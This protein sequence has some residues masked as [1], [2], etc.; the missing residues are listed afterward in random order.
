[1]V[2]QFTLNAGKRYPTPQY[3]HL[4]PLLNIMGLQNQAWFAHRCLSVEKM[5]AVTLCPHSMSWSSVNSGKSR[6][7]PAPGSTRKRCW[8]PFPLHTC[9]ISPWHLPGMWQ[10]WLWW[11]HLLGT[12]PKAG[13]ISDKSCHCFNVLI[14]N[15]LIPG[16][17]GCTM[18][19]FLLQE[20]ESSVGHPADP[21]AEKTKDIFQEWTCVMQPVKSMLGA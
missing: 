5:M 15:L 14:Q 20:R 8:T 12:A 18:H 9:G 2:F 11:S 21:Q 6:Y 3:L 16:K 10:G 1:M 7:Y 4:S 17:W 19:W 13:N